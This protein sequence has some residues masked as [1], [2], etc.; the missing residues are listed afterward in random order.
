MASFV[1]QEL[2]DGMLKAYFKG[3]AAPTQLYLRLYTDNANIAEATVLTDIASLEQAG[4]G[5]A[6]KTLTAANWTV[7]AGTG[8]WQVVLANQTWT[9]TA[10]NWGTLR[11]AVIT[12]TADNTGSILLAKD[13]GTGKTV[14]GVGANVTISQL[15]YQIND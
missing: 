12:T 2:R 15:Y 1:S 4:S 8:G 9:T 3:T 7:Q 14:T 6:A 13:Y 5:Y 11:W 10:D